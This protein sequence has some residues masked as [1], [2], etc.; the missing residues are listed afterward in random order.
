MFACLPLVAPRR[1]TLACAAPLEAKLWVFCHAELRA[2]RCPGW[3][4]TRL[5]AA[6]RTP[7]THSAIRYRLTCSLHTRPRPLLLS[8]LMLLPATPYRNL[9]YSA[10]FTC[11]YLPSSLHITFIFSPRPFLPLPLHLTHTSPSFPSQPFLPSCFLRTLPTALLPF[12][13]LLSLT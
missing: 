11:P 10:P 8:S 6:P 13:S 9:H 12:A 3:R 7:I 2:S 5:V 4:H 1:V